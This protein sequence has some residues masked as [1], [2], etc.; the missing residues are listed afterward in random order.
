MNWGYKILIVFV[1]FGG[2]IGYMVY[3]DWRLTLV[4]AVIGPAVVLLTQQLGA[5]LRRYSHQVQS[6]LAD[7]TAHVSEAFA[8]TRVI[9]IFGLESV[10]VRRFDHQ[11][12]EKG[13]IDMVSN[14]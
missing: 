9:K 10:V 11:A 7:L 5:R 4:M 2:M 1:L 6:C 14:Y 12:R 13:N 8:M 3:L